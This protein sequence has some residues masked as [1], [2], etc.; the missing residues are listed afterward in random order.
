MFAF[1]KRICKQHYFSH[2]IYQIFTTKDK[3]DYPTSK[4]HIKYINLYLRYKSIIF[5]NRVRG[6]KTII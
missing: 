5:I 4:L 1:I 3:L 2:E 6:K